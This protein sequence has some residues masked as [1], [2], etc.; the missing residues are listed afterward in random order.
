MCLFDINAVKK[1][2]IYLNVYN[3][4]QSIYKNETTYEAQKNMSLKKK[5]LF[6]IEIYIR[7]H[8]LLLTSSHFLNIFIK[9]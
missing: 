5:I 8:K 3:K 1:Y 6:I 7:F 2:V 9:F 4:M